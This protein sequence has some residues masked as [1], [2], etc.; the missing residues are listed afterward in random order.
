MLVRHNEISKECRNFIFKEQ[1][2]LLGL[3]EKAKEKPT[4]TPSKVDKQ[5]LLERVCCASMDGRACAASPVKVIAKDASEASPRGIL[6][7]N[8]P[9]W[10]R[11]KE[12]ASGLRV[13]MA[14]MHCRTW[15]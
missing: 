13:L 14:T 12:G 11:G 8:C 4:P 2:L 3:R 7:Q 9:R 15:C 6:L 10:V 5:A 1:L